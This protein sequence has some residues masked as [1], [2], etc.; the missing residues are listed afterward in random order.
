MPARY[1]ASLL[2]FT[3]VVAGCTIGA[4]AE[5]TPE[6]V[7]Q[8]PTPM[9]TPERSDDGGVT[10]T[11]A[12]SSTPAPTLDPAAFDLE[13][14]T[15]PGGVVLDWA[16]TTHPS[17]HHYSALRSPEKEIPPDWPP[18][19]PAVDWGHSYTT[20]RFV[21]AAVDA[22]ILPSDTQWY[23]RVIAY[24]ARDREIAQSPVREAKMRERTGL[25]DLGVGTGPDGRTR[26]SWTPYPGNPECFSSY[27]IIAGSGGTP[28]TL[29]VVTEQA[30]GSLQTDALRSGVT[31]ELLVR[32]VV[33]T[34]LGSFVLGETDPVTFTV[35]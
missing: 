16:P 32:A 3:F 17:F 8:R 20:D 18:V 29:T 33:T 5:L 21:T 14:I 9:P 25:G 28:H 11:A 6:E 10:P 15:C 34:T 26:L 23:Y 30:A 19:A 27:Q 7:T 4:P 12:P 2:T 13:A 31:Y 35:P 24:D 1:R 22:S